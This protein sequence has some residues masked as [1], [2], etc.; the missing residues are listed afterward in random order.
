[1]LPK[2]WIIKL[3]PENSDIVGKYYNDKCSTIDNTVQCYTSSSSL[4]SYLSSHELTPH[5]KY[6]GGPKG[7]GN[8]GQFNASFFCSDEWAREITTE[9]FVKY[10]LKQEPQEVIYEIY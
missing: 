7:G 3:T 10:V 9:D 4:G 6:I 5:G 8:E 1:M 2:K